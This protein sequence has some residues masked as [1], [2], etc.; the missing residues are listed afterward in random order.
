MGFTVYALHNQ[1]SNKIYIGQTVNIEKRLREHN[2]KRGKHFTA[3]VS[4]Q[5][6]LVYSEQYETRTEALVRE[7]Q[8]KS[9]QGRKFIKSK[10]K[11][12]E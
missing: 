11:N 4:G 7:K 10:I 12:I 5:W 9:Y 6:K 3:L 1:E 2:L 8:L